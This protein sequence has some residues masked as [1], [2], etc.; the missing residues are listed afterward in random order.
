MTA[1]M[2]LG[3]LG[4]HIEHTHSY[5]RFLA[6]CRRVSTPHFIDMRGNYELLIE[7]NDEVREM[8]ADKRVFKFFPNSLG[9]WVALRLPSG[10]YT[11]NCMDSPEA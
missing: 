10:S 11:P 8:Q 2:G 3:F 5:T 6:N 4:M 9:Q 1:K 7:K